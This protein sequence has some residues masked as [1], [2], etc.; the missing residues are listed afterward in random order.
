[1]ARRMTDGSGKLWEGDR[2][3]RG[4]GS[5]L[6]ALPLR[7]R[8]MARRALVKW[9]GSKPPLRTSTATSSIPHRMIRKLSRGCQPL[10][11]FD[12]AP[13]SEEEPGGEGIV[14][15]EDELVHAREPRAP[16][17]LRDDPVVRA[18]PRRRDDPGLEA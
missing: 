12:R 9:S 16:G 4:D 11:P 15:L 7:R 2:I 18:D 6:S 14:R 13:R 17:D 8:V 5:T 3:T 1:M 10:S